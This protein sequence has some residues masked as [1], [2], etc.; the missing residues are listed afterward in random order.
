MDPQRRR[1]LLLWTGSIVLALAF[2]LS[3]S[4][5]LMNGQTQGGGDWDAQFVAWGFPAWARWIVGGAE[6]LAAVALVVPRARFYGA[7]TL[8]ALMVGAI[9]THLLNGEAAYAGVPFFLGALAA[10]LAWFTRP[11]WV[12]LLLARRGAQAV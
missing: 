2:L 3:G 10:T 12:Q 11:A 8:T 9:G 5:K 6:V 4:G 1:S 7:A